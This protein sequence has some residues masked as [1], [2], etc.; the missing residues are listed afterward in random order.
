MYTV[1]VADDEKELR[2]ALIRNVNWAEIGFQLVGEAENGAEALELVEK[3]EPDLLLTDI[4]MPF[5]SGIEL[6]RQVREVK[7]ATQIAFL[8]GYDDFSYA[9]QAIQYNII[10][11]ILKPVSA[12]EINEELINIKNKIDEK[13]K[14]FTAHNQTQEQLKA[15]EFLLPLMLDGFRGSLSEKQQ[16]GI[17][18]NAV[19]FGILNAKNSELRYAVTVVEIFDEDGENITEPANVNAVDTILKKYVKHMSFYIEG[20]VVSLLVATGA[21]FDKYLHILTE[22]IAQSVHRIMKKVCVIGISRAV[23]KLE[24]VHESYIE[25]VNAVGYSKRNGNGIQFISDIER[26]DEYDVEGMKSFSNDVE[27]LIRGGTCLELENYLNNTFDKM[28]EAHVSITTMNFVMVQMILAVFQ[29]VYAVADYDMLQE[30][31]KQNPLSSRIAYEDFSKLKKK[32]IGFCLTA[33]KIIAEQRK[34]S[35]ALICDKALKLIETRYMDPDISLVS[36]ST[37]I[38]VSPNYLSALIKKSTGSTFTDI[39]TKKRITIAKEMILCTSMKVREI[40]EKCGYNDQHYFSYCFKRVVGISP[41]ACR[42]EYEERMAE[43]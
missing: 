43:A 22:E 3:L 13:Y 17:L 7:P 23:E 8:S 26:A 11:Y 27:S 24:N 34:K 12:A 32:Y 29:I 36:I 28:M 40:S 39:L 1:V 31:Q 6:A 33:Q 19:R 41:N 10:S 35:S 14:E 20:K 30:L 15:A 21:G 25:A 38:A 2:K 37:E 16:E 42:R 18:E 4:K 9:Q 5:L